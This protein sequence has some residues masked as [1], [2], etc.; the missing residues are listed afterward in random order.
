MGH[1]TCEGRTTDLRRSKGLKFKMYV[2]IT[3]LH[4]PHPILDTEERIRRDERGEGT[5]FSLT[6]AASGCRE[7]VLEMGVQLECG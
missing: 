7:D 2:Q 6:R 4:P 1:H 3:R 5:R